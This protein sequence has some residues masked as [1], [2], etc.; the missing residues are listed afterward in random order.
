MR[1]CY[2]PIFILFSQCCFAYLRSFVILHK[3]RTV[4]SISVKMFY[5]HVHKYRYTMECYLAMRKKKILAYM[6]TWMHLEGIILNEISQAD[7][8]QK[9]KIF[10]YI[11][12]CRI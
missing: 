10:Y 6:M 4:L 3:S 12:T 8:K 2:D 5:T 11:I 9:K 1:T 7:K